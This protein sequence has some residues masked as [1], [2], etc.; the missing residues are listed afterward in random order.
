MREILYRGKGANQGGKRENDR[1][2][3]KVT[4]SKFEVL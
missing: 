4:L 3:E 2:T 1:V